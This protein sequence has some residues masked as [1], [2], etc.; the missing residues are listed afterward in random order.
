[1]D[2]VSSKDKTYLCVESGHVGL[3]LS[4]MFAGIVDQWAASRSNPLSK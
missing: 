3:A 4:G 1:M 2:L